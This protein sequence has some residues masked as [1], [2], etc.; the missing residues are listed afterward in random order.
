M[1]AIQSV[2]QS[3]VTFEHLTTE[4]YD[5]DLSDEDDQYNDTKPF[6]TFEVE[7]TLARSECP[8]IEH[9]PEL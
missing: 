9:V 2:R 4:L 6:T 3:G 1:I 8:C 7:C 5:D